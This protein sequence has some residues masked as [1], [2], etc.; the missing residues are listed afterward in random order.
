M[1]DFFVYLICLCSRK[2]QIFQFMP[3]LVRVLVSTSKSYFIHKTKAVRV[4]F[5]NDFF[6]CF[7]EFE[8]HQIHLRSHKFI[9]KMGIYSSDKAFG[10]IAH[11]SIHNV[12]SYV[13]HASRCILYGV[14]PSNVSAHSIDITTY[15]RIRGLFNCDF[16][17]VFNRINVGQFFYL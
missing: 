5:S 3:F 15:Q 6:V 14:A 4:I 10:T 17:T 9:G 11:P 16:L 7:L 2:Q 1:P 12:R 8:F 13:L